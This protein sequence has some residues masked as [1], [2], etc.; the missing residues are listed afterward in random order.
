M[1]T[2]TESIVPGSHRAHGSLPT[3]ISYCTIFRFSANSSTNCGDQRVALY[4]GLYV[5]LFLSVCSY[6]CRKFS[7][8]K[9]LNCCF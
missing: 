1:G 5:T 9:Y 8:S 6:F 3:E 7:K 4:R 2:G